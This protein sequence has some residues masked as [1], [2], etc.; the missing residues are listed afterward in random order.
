MANPL[1][2]LMAKMPDVRGAVEENLQN[3]LLQQG[4]NQKAAEFQQAQEDRTRQQ[5]QLSQNQEL[6]SMAQGAQ[7]IIPL[8]EAGDTIG[9]QKVLGRRYDDILARGGDP[10][11]TL[12]AMQ[13]IGSNDPA[14]I[15]EV[16]QLAEST[17]REA[18][19]RGLFKDVGI[20]RE[21]LDLR[22]REFKQRQLEFETEQTQE[23]KDLIFKQKQLQLARE[24]EARQQEKL[25][26]GL[27]KRL[28]ESQ[29]LAELSSRQATEFNIL[30]DQVEA[31][32][33]SGGFVAGTSELFKRFLGTQDDVTE[34]R[35]RF[36]KVRL[37]EGLK[38]LPPGPATDRDVQEA[39]KGVP[40]ENAPAQQIISFLRGA[41]KLAKYDSAYNQFK[42]D[43]ISNESTSKGLLKAWRGK[44]T[45]S[46]LGREVT[47]AEVYAEAVEAG[48]TVDDVKQQLGI[49]E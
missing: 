48:L 15:A 32:D 42:S 1:I 37:S 17:V 19:Q 35:R 21:K 22:E 41:A 18:K 30:A 25:S 33:L 20:E 49:T 3:Q 6:F 11:D 31:L 47:L 12:E 2:A 24:R 23:E 39:F 38:N 36:N 5:Q 46:V 10:S 29:D 26:A 45:S 40:P 14:Q 44:V 28:I 9:A 27:E 43:Y 34:L 16:K 8:L 7:D 13:M 4:L